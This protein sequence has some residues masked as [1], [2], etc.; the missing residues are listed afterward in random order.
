MFG[1]HL[2]KTGKIEKEFSDIITEEQEDRIM[3]LIWK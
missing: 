1:L 2:V 3:K